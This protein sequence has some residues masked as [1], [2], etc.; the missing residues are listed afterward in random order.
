MPLIPVL[1]G[2]M[3]LNK[4]AETIEHILLNSDKRDV[5]SKNAIE[6][7]NKK[8]TWQKATDT[9]IEYFQTTINQ[10]G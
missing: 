2:Q 9:L 4:F 7:V 1:R 10:N 3:V 8:W 5:L 6:S